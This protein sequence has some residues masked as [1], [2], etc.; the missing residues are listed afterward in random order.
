MP[1][2][3]RTLSTTQTEGR[4]M[5]PA[6][7]LTRVNRVVAGIKRWERKKKTAET[8]LAKLRKQLKYYQQKGLVL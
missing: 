3:W 8:K 7:Q 1:T 6:I 2:C 5:T 4:S